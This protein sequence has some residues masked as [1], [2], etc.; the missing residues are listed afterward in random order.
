MSAPTSAAVAGSGKKGNSWYLSP[1][2]KR[3][4]SAFNLAEWL[5]DRNVAEGRGGK[6]ALRCGDDALTYA[7]LQ[8]MANRTANGLR[9]L[10][11]RPEDRVLLVLPDGVEF[12]ASWFG[13]LKAG[14]V[15]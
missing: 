8:A 15:F 3:M 9:E 10:G 12:A 1:T 11:V 2:V 13:L 7:Q 6:V 14:A 5:L 4:H